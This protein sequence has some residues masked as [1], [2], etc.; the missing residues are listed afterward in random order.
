MCKDDHE[1]CDGFTAT[2][3]SELGEDTGKEDIKSLFLV[4]PVEGDAKS[5]VFP[6]IIDGNERKR[7]YGTVVSW[8]DKKYRIRTLNNIYHDSQKILGP[9]SHILEQIS[10]WF[11]TDFAGG[12]KGGSSIRNRPRVENALKK[13]LGDAGY[14]AVVLYVT[15]FWNSMWSGETHR[16]VD[17]FNYKT[18]FC[19]P[20]WYYL[21]RIL[22]FHWKK[23]PL[24]PFKS[25][26]TKIT[27][28]KV[29]LSSITS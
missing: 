29:Y 18:R 16:A 25:A 14:A 19:Q 27:S 15:E 12:Y 8:C 10:L 26:I 7:I 20:E 6:S 3:M 17:D 13:H 4:T 28:L 22:F 11:D 2:V 1:A 21:G 23:E 5:Y 24:Y 9:W